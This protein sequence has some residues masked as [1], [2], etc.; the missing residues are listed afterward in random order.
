M[1]RGENRGNKRRFDRGKGSQSSY[2]PTP[3]RGPPAIFLTCESGREKKCQREALELMHHYYYASR[4]AVQNET[5]SEDETAAASSLATSSTQKETLE[6]APLSLE[7][8]VAM[9]RKGAAAEEVLSYEPNSKR[10]RNASTSSMKSPF[11]IYDTGMRGMICILCNLPGCEMVPYDKILAEIKAA[12]EKE[13]NDA[14]TTNVD[15][16]GN[17]DSKKSDE[18]GNVTAAKNPVSKASTKED[19]PP[20]WDP[21]ETVM[22]IMRDAKI[23]RKEG[24]D[25]KHDSTNE[26]GDI[27]DQKEDGE[28]KEIK[29]T[30][31]G[32]KNID[33]KEDSE[34]ETSVS[35]ELLASP[36]PGSRFISRILPM[37]ATCFASVDEVKAVSISLLKQCLPS[38]HDILAKDGK[39]ITFKVEI[40]RRLCS[41]MTREQVIEAITPVVLGGLEEMPGYKFS[42]NLSDPDFS[43]RIETCKSLCGVSILP[44][45]DWHRNFNLAEVVNPTLDEK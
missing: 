44:R 35:K 39:D 30:N 38:F 23:L 40:K 18:N 13:S 19:G 3:R 37:Q 7:E 29:E 8:E 2:G 10:P 42:V 24:D 31:E 28:K 27:L 26:G 5:K 43:I 4:T 15:A 33:Q 41:H 20:I 25:T 14:T 21:V 17:D 34:K 9:L 22:C 16:T 36:P 12:K 32:G 11:S 45:A 6:E 1:A